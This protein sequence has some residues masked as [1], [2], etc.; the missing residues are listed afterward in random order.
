MNIYFRVPFKYK[1]DT[2]SNVRSLFEEL[3]RLGHNV[4]LSDKSVEPFSPSVETDLIM[5]HGTAATIPQ[6]IFDKRIIPIIS[7]GWSDPNLYAPY[8][9]KTCDVYFTNDLS[10]SQRLSKALN[11]FYL[12]TACNKK[13]H[14]YLGLAKETDILVYGVGVH[15]VVKDRNQTVDWLRS[16]GFTIKVFG[17]NWNPHKDTHPF[18]EGEELIVEINKAHLCLDLSNSYT[19]F[20]HRILECSACG[21][22]V[23][24]FRRE[25]T[26][27]LLENERE[28]FTYASKEELPYILNAILKNGQF[29]KDVGANAQ[30]RCYKD[31]NITNR[32]QELKEKLYSVG[33]NL[34]VGES[35]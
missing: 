1:W 21:T 15:P 9:A 3:Q 30:R 18:I 26:L 34:S 23:L 32:V 5:L 29:L 19:A 6:Y 10:L 11:C 28:I 24:T 13:Y 31:H 17:R 33:I 12:Q 35:K 22:P 7:F 27:S 14:R 8:F 2:F 20:P 4:T 25:D 16:M